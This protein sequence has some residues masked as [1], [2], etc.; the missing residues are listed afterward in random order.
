MGERPEAVICTECGRKPAE[1]GKDCCFNCRVRSVGLSFVG[2][3]GKTRQLFHDY[4]IKERQA[5]MLG[6]RVLGKDVLPASEFGW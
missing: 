6:D 1:E 3:G 2:G 4:T 5:E